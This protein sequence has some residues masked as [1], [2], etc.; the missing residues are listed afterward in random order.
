MRIQE[1]TT[2]QIWKYLLSWNIVADRTLK[3]LL[4]ALLK[5]S[6]YI[7]QTSGTLQRLGTHQQRGGSGI[8]KML[9]EHSFKGLPMVSQS[10]ALVLENPLIRFASG[11]EW[12]LLHIPPKPYSAGRAIKTKNPSTV[13]LDKARPLQRTGEVF[14][15]TVENCHCYYANG[16]LT[17]N[18]DVFTQAAI[19]LRDAGW[20]EGKAAPV[21]DIDEIDYVQKRE[22]RINPY[23]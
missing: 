9:N 21:E 18:C 19:Y 8:A 1:I 11:A 17:H 5:S 10:S 20:L 15:L 23:S 13:V 22:A 12:S 16:F 3:L 6:K 7:W 14:N 2:S 4:G